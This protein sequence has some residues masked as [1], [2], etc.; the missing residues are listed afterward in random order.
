[1][2]GDL[3]TGSA[4]ELVRWP[5]IGRAARGGGWSRQ[6]EPTLDRIDAALAEGR[7]E[8]AAALV[9]HL[10][11]EATEIHEL[12]TEWGEEIPR[13]LI[14]EGMDRERVEEIG[15][16]LAA[17]AGGADP[18]AGWREFGRRA[19]R[20]AAAI[21]AGEAGEE[22]AA[23]EV[24]ATVEAWLASHDPQ[25]VV[26]AGWVDAAVRELGE[27]SLG[28]LWAVLQRAPIESYGR[29]DVRDSPWERS[30]ALLVQI[31]LEGMHAHYGGPRRRGEI[32]L[33]EHPD[34]IEMRF[35]PCGSGGRIRREEL[36]GVTGERHPFAWNELG[37]C[38]YCV[39]CC[40]LQQLEPIRRLGYPARVI[41][42]PTEPGAECSW[43]VY[44]DPSLVPDSAYERVGEAP[45]RR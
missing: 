3:L 17:R 45:P 20:T 1:V 24:R 19:E 27:A 21:A 34:R 23:A 35:A 40:V 28:E 44:R 18:E 15:A 41:E 30:F 11:V 12:L 36:F 6:A 39:H 16:E 43:S 31:A 33:I 32:E 10:V 9:R 4:E 29:Y 37:V 38:H 13:I 25:L 2:P 8:D 7:R 42:P 5:P 26:T 22:E 14:R